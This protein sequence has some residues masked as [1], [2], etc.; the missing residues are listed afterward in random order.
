MSTKLFSLLIAIV[1]SVGL[2]L[3][4]FLVSIVDAGGKYMEPIENLS[5]RPSML[6]GTPS[7][8]LIAAMKEKLSG[9]G[10][11]KESSF[12]GEY[13]LE[14]ERALDEYRKANGLEKDKTLKK[15]L[16]SLGLMNGN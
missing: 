16:K 12:N 11:Y 1:L 8:N 2:L 10:Y 4:G 9:K 14:F 7:W 6:T 15:T 3:N 5:G 13:T